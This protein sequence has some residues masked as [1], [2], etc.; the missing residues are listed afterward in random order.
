MNKLLES[1]KLTFLYDLIF[2]I[3]Q[4]LQVII[5][6]FRNHQISTPHLIKQRVVKIYAK[7]YDIQ[8]FI[9]TGTYLGT[10]VNATKNIFPK[11]YTIEL[12]K[13]LYERAKNKFKGI[14]SIK[15]LFGDS[16][17]VLPNLLKEINKPALFWLDA[18]YSKGIT[19]KGDKETPILEELT[20]ILNHKIK[21]HVIL[22]DDANAFTSKNDYPAKNHLKKFILDKNPNLKFEVKQNI[23]LITP[24]PHLLLKED[25]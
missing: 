25:R 6:H 23:I 10:M 3:V 19:S 22:I 8:T 4:T 16:A 21:N 7:K 14:S 18:H 1:L 17:L 24:R 5:W 2:P 12:D 11:I 13:K 20:A 9:E 15:V